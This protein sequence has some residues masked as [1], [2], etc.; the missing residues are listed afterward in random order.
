MNEYLDKQIGI[1]QQ[2]LDYALQNWHVLYPDNVKEKVL[3]WIK[4][5]LVG[6]CQN[7]QYI[8]DQIGNGSQL[9]MNN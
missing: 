9:I 1:A 4:H 3:Q 8:C 7:G 6:Y 5:E 2:G